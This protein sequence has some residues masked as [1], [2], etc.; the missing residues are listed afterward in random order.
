MR[1]FLIL[2]AALSQ[3]LTQQSSETSSLVSE[4]PVLFEPVDRS[5]YVLGAGDILQ[6]TITGGCT[7]LMLYSGVQPQSVCIVS[8]DGFLPVPGLGQVEAQGFTISETEERIL[9][10]ARRYYPR[11]SLGIALVE[12]RVIKVYIGGM[13]ASPGTYTLSAINRVSDLVTLAGG[14]TSYSSRSGNMYLENGDTV[15]VDLRMDPATHARAADPF[16]QGNSS[17]IFDLC[18]NPVYILREGAVPELPGENPVSS[19]ETWDIEPGT[20][21]TYLLEQIGGLG[22]NMDLERS[23]LVQDQARYPVWTPEYGLLDIIVM[24]GDTLTLVMLSDSIALGGALN[25]TGWIRF[26]PG[27]TAREYIDMSGGIR[28]DGDMGRT[29]VFRG[30]EQIASGSEALDLVLLPGDVVEVP[31][32]WI[33]RN[34]EWIRVL[35]VA[36]T[37]VVMVDG[38][39]N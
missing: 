6:V 9:A 36:V 3:I 38:L 33:A 10:L 24:P 25:R 20:D 34:A 37:I 15:S 16:V 39:T 17:V 22:G 23:L 26:R 12:P 31:W 18:E 13:I 11:I 29:R 21:L 30:G 27:V 2:L 1:T 5:E 14:L 4:E 32:T 8:G 19:I 7:E 28:S 35:S